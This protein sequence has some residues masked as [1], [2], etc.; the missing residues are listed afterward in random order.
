MILRIFS[1][2]EKRCSWM[3]AFLMI[4]YWSYRGW[5]DSEFSFLKNVFLTIREASYKINVLCV[6]RFLLRF[7]V[8]VVR[9]GWSRTSLINNSKSICVPEDLSERITS[10]STNT[11]N[12][13]NCFTKINSRLLSVKNAVIAVHAPKLSISRKTKLMKN[14]KI[15]DV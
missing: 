9:L 10:P 7:E 5:S 1:L 14:M 15:Q 12:T 3:H 6:K 4:R 13:I 11:P 8:V 2:E